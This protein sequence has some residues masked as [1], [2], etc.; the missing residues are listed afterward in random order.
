MSKV[1]VLKRMSLFKDSN[2]IALELALNYTDYYCVEGALQIKELWK[3]T[4]QMGKE[5]RR[6]RK[7]LE[8]VEIQASK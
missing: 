2:E 8:D 3:L 4:K 6:L 1:D 5:I 7:L